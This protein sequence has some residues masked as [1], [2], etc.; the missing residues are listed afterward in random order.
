MEAAGQALLGCDLCGWG[1]QHAVLQCLKGSWGWSRPEAVEEWFFF[2]SSTS[3]ETRSSGMLFPILLHINMCHL[4]SLEVLSNLSTLHALKSV[5]RYSKP[6]RKWEASP[7]HQMCW[8]CKMTVSGS[9]C[10]RNTWQPLWIFR[11]T[12]ASAPQGHW[13]ERW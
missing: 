12:N 3:L 2:F 10:Y 5:S 9:L 6:N 8:S 1:A 11:G 4:I 7:V 13:M